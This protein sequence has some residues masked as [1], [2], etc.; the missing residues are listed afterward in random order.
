LAKSTPCPFAVGGLLVFFSVSALLEPKKADAKEVALF[1][2]VATFF[3]SL[4][5]G[6]EGP[7]GMEGLRRRPETR[8]WLANSFALPN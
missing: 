7:E 8:Q 2:F 5:R 1:F 4:R 6:V 3:S